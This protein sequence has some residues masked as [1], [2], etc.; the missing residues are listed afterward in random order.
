MNLEKILIGARVNDEIV[1]IDYCLN[2][3]DRVV[4]LT[5]ELAYGNRKDLIKKANTEYAKMKIKN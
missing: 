1:P 5:D 3:K 2:N 4:V